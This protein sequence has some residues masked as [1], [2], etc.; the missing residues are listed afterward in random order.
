M[1]RVCGLLCVWI[2]AAGISIV[3]LA[4]A[5]GAPPKPGFAG[6]PS[7]KA[8]AGGYRIEFAV[9]QSTD[10]AVEITCDGR[11]VR[12]LAAGVLG[13]PKPP[14]AP[15]TPGLKQSI[16]WDGNDDAGKQVA[17]DKP[18]QARVRLGLGVEFDR[19]VADRKEAGPRDPIQPGLAVGERNSLAI[20]S[21]G[22]ILLLLTYGTAGI[23]GR[24]ENRL[25]MLS[26]QGKYI[27]SLAPYR[28]NTPA[29]KLPGVDF[30]SAEPGRLTPRVYE[31]VCT[32]LLP[33]FVAL[34]LQTMAITPDDRLV[35]SSGWR[36]ELYGFGPRSLLA[37]NADGSI[38]RPRFDGPVLA[39]GQMGGFLHIGLS[40]DARHVYATGFSEGR[41][42]E[43]ARNPKTLLHTVL[44]VEL[45]ADAKPELFFGKPKTPGAGHELLND[46]RGL[47]VDG[48]GNVYISDHM[49]DRI[50]VLSPD[51]RF[52]RQIECVR[53]MTLVMHPK[54]GSIYVYRYDGELAKLDGDG[55]QI[56][57]YSLGRINSPDH[58]HYLPSLAIDA[59]GE[60]PIIYAGANNI[61]RWRL[62]RIADEGPAAKATELLP[63]QAGLGDEVVSVT[64]DDTL[65]VRQSMGGNSAVSF[66]E[67]GATG[68]RRPWWPKYYDRVYLARDGLSYTYKSDPKTRY[69]QVWLERST[70]AREP[71]PF[72]TADRFSEPANGLFWAGRRGNLF[73]RPSGD[74]YYLE[75]NEQGGGKSDILRYDADGRLAGRA[76]TGLLGPIAVK[77]DKN[78]NV[79]TA[80]NLKPE[81]THWPKELDGFVWKLDAKGQDEY[82]EIYG[83]VL[84]FRPTGGSV[85]PAGGDAPAG[86]RIMELCKGEKKFAVEGLADCFV[87]ISP[88]GPLRTGFKSKCW[89][90][91]ANFD[92]DPHDRLF[93]PDS[94]RFRVHVLDANFNPILDFGGYDSIDAPQGKANAPGPEISF[95][96]PLAV[97]VSDAA[98]Y[99]YDAAPCARRTLRI[100]LTYAAQESCQIR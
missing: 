31:R 87:G 54:S 53:P 43:P 74:F 6:R 50:V 25:I 19:F 67:N 84:K 21:K 62:L 77:V 75:Y 18:V 9:D 88:V 73:V 86:S 99:V 65:Y 2:V 32:A 100:K 52:L 10:V 89:C 46:P 11:I 4:S 93:V 7:V 63:P 38:P 96:C 85:R 34:P 22:N 94:A 15:L 44:R 45:A 35:L 14:P 97:N 23:A 83:S 90:L 82:A 47:A 95:E 48:R 20:D 55:R 98:A 37:I 64:P 58:V 30:V 42:Y 79:F 12:H 26:P 40:P 68:E 76:V 16:L 1:A 41:Y 72:A 91:G 92:L 69:G 60:Q 61:G 33:Q 81:G 36:T 13:G 49:N 39:E 66:L 29:D 56:W 28:A 5:A 51:G 17:A 3:D 24:T 80:D 27:R 71:A 8:D 78:G 70:T 59:R 57:A